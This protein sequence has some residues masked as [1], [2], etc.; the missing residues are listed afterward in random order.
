MLVF[1]TLSHKSYTYRCVNAMDWYDL[2]PALKH[3]GELHDHNRA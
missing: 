2:G 1:Y 3:M